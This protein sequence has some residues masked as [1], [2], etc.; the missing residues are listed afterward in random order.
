MSKVINNYRHHVKGTFW[1]CV[2]LAGPGVLMGASI[3][4]LF[5]KYVMPFHW[6][7]TMS[8]VFGS[9]VTATDPVAVVSILK[10]SGAKPSLIMIIV[11][12]SLMNDG[13]AMVLFGLF[14]GV[15]QGEAVLSVG[16]TAVYLL[17]SVLGRYGQMYVRNIFETCN[18]C[19]R[20]VGAQGLPLWG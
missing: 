13:T 20:C 16:D 1:Q 9:I 4:C 7:W 10:A 15:L 8:M 2:I 11:G 12:E 14:F 17:K 6:S 19:V 18:I 3:T 5:C